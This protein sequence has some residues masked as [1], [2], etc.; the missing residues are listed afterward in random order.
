[1]EMLT[2]LKINLSKPIKEQ[3]HNIFAFDKDIETFYSGSKSI[4]GVKSYR[5]SVPYQGTQKY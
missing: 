4:E 3:V 1:M 5:D 2:K